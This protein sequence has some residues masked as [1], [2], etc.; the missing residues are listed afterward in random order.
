MAGWNGGCSGRVHPHL[1]MEMPMIQIRCHCRPVVPAVVSLLA[2]LFT[3]GCLSDGQTGSQGL[4]RFSQVVDYA[5]TNG[6]T[7]PIAAGRPVLVALQ[8]PQE[9][10]PVA[11]TDVPFTDGSTRADL[12]LRV[13][14][15]DSPGQDAG[16]VWPLGFA[17]FAVRIEDEGQYDLVAT[18]NGQDLD[19]VTV[20]VK[21]VRRVRLSTQVIVTTSDGR[22]Q[23]TS[24][25]DVSSDN[26]VLYRN[27]QVTAEIV[28]LDDQDNPMLGQLPLVVSIEGGDGGSQALDAP[29]I[30]QGQ[31]ANA[32]T[33]DAAGVGDGDTV[34]DVTESLLG[35]TLSWRV[36]TRGSDAPAS[37]S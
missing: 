36:Q 15:S 13:Q 4:V 29:L 33:F 27:Q 2:V 22:G 17:Q 14:R 20:E 25:A 6:F 31:S 19:S 35:Q 32:F 30:G 18:Q 1:E 21:A 8:N 34:L 23:C 26:M 11:G 5:E 37:C 24:S 16:E 10:L 28:A 9:T 3:V 12:Q 7:A